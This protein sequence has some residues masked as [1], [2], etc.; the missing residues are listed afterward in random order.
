MRVEWRKRD[1]SLT[2]AMFERVT[3]R[4]EGIQ[5]KFPDE[6]LKFTVS[7]IQNKGSKKP[8][9]YRMKGILS[10]NGLTIK[11]ESRQMDY[12]DAVD[13]MMDT[14]LHNFKKERDKKEKQNRDSRRELKEYFKLTD[15]PIDEY[16]EEFYEYN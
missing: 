15:E 16:E 12:Y 6:D 14:L 1:V 7:L 2:P 3:Q 5:S 4:A 11:A 13:D 9:S 10:S 8:Y